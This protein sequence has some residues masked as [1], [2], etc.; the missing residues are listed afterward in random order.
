MCLGQACTTI[1][2]QQS[3]ENA[4]AP[5]GGKLVGEQYRLGWITDLAIKGDKDRGLA[6]H[7]A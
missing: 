2:D 7:G 4:V 6:G 5:H 1:A 3:L